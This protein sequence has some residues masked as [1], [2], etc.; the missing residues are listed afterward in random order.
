[1]EENK[2]IVIRIGFNNDEDYIIRLETD[3]A[4]VIAREFHEA[5]HWHGKTTRLGKS[6]EYIA[7]AMT[8]TTNTILLKE[9]NK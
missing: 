5:S 2:D 3:E 1:M 9:D 7:N 8:Y 4:R 6:F